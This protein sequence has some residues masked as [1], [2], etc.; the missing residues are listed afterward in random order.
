MPRR[1]TSDPFAAMVG[2]RVQTL[3]HE[4]K[5]TLDQLA[6]KTGIPKGHLSSLENGRVVMRLHTAEKLAKGLD[7]KLLDIFTFPEQDNRQRLVDAMR[8]APPHELAALEQQFRRLTD[9]AERIDES[10][11]TWTRRA[12]SPVP[13]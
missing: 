8:N 5:L 11:T 3:R 4:K 13:C 6:Q 12:S 2:Q 7:L 10:F 1:S 9:A